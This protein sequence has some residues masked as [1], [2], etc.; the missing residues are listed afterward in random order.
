MAAVEQKQQTLL[1]AECQRLAVQLEA[2][3]AMVEDQQAALEAERQWCAV[4]ESRKQTAIS[5]GVGLS[6][7]RSLHT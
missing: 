6:A 3:T 2:A 4:S 7:V 1:E 5:P